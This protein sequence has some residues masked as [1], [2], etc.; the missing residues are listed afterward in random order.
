VLGHYAEGPQLFHF[1][2]I[3]NHLNSTL[4]ELINHSSRYTDPAETASDLFDCLAV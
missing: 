3:Y 4:H 2:L 1:E